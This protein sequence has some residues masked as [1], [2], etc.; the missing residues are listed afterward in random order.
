MSAALIAIALLVSAACVALAWAQ[1]RRVLRSSSPDIRALATT[2][3]SLPLP[4]RAE[5]LAR[6]AQPESWEHGLAQSLLEASS[7]DDD[8]YKT[9]VA[10]ANDALAEMDNTL[11]VGASWP[12]GAVRVCARSSLLLAVIAFIIERSATAILPLLIIGGAGSFACIIIG[13]RSQ[14]EARERREAIDAL[15]NA[16]TEAQSRDSDL[17]ASAGGSKQS[18]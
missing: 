7:G 16:L 12:G 9:R 11:R 18:P 4:S 2:L 17:P 8:D 3:K 13:R 10:A 1:L 6:R 14:R 5:E 15:V